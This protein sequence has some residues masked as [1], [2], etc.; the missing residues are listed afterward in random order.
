[1]NGA[2]HYG[3]TRRWALEEGFAADEAEVVAR[4]DIGVDR[5][6]PGSEWRNWGWHFGL[7]GAWVRARRLE[8]ESHEASDLTKLGEA[9]H[10][11]QDG[12]SHGLVGHVW[13]WDGIDIWERRSESVRRR[14]ERRSRAMLAAYRRAVGPA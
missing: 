10:C 13:H 5:K 2:V 9:L 1:M 11:A 8:R 3:L 14:I 6:H 12:I 7:A 4:A